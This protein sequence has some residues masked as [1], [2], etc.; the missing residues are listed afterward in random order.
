MFFHTEWISWSSRFLLPNQEMRDECD[1]KQKQSLLT[2]TGGVGEKTTNIPFVFRIWVNTVFIPKRNA[3]NCC[4]SV[5]RSTDIR[6]NYCPLK[7]AKFGKPFIITMWFVHSRT[8]QFSA[9]EQ[10]VRQVEGGITPFYA[11][12][13]HMRTVLTSWIPI[14]FP[15]VT[16]K[17]VTSSN[18]PIG[19]KYPMTMM[20]V[21]FTFFFYFYYFYF[22]LLNDLGKLL[23]ITSYDPSMFWAQ[24]RQVY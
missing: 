2:I 18:S 13:N 17:Y 9:A 19:P 8:A 20:K 14:L 21:N 7:N 11:I 16:W 15:L 1:Q 5:T 23:Q 10:F 3:L 6:S 12:L 22:P 24:V 4:H